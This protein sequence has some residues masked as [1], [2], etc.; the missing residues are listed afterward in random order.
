MDSFRIGRDLSSLLPSFCP[1][2]FP[3]FAVDPFGMVLYGLV[4]SR[5]VSYRLVWSRIVSYRL[6]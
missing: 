3:S 1:F 6:I 4:W 2:F 5:M